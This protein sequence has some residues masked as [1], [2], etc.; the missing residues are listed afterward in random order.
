MSAPRELNCL[1]DI[2]ILTVD[3]A[4]APIAE[5]RLSEIYNGETSTLK[6]DFL[7]VFQ[8]YIALQLEKT[9]GLSDQSRSRLLNTRF[10]CMH[11]RANGEFLSLRKPALERLIRQTIQGQL[12]AFSPVSVSI[13]IQF[14]TPGWCIPKHVHNSPQNPPKIVG[15]GRGISDVGSHATFATSRSGGA[16]IIAITEIDS[17][18]TCNLGNMISVAKSGVTFVPA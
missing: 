7:V 18:G 13:R 15:L 3:V 9:N 17:P 16:D 10:I 12:D 5:L 11:R 6:N 14:K 1:D 8:A 2:V 4:D